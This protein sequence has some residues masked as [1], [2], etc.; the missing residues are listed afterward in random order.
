MRR[1]CLCHT[2]I[3][4]GYVVDSVHC[5]NIF[6]PLAL[7]WWERLCSRA[8][9]ITMLVPN[10]NPRRFA[11]IL[12]RYLADQDSEWSPLG[13]PLALVKV[14]AL[15][16]GHREIMNNDRHLM[17]WEREVWNRFYLFFPTLA[18]FLFEP[19]FTIQIAKSSLMP[20]ALSFSVFL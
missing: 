1:S 3:S 19:Q 5:V 17:T 16:I 10:T 2:L 15:W 13:P 14:T 12:L 11:H 6:P 9:Q 8:R 4:C 7:C 20:R 18:V